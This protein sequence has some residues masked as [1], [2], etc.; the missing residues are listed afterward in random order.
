M[1]FVNPGFLYG[2]LAVSI[3][4]I[5]HLFNFRRFKKVYFTNVA[6][7]RELKQETQK[8]SRLK[9]LLVLLMRMLA[10]VALVL[11]FAR[12]FIPLKDNLI[13]PLETNSI[14]IYVDNSFSMQA[15][16]DKGTLLE[17]A[18]E[19]ALEI[20][21][22]Y[23]ASDRFQLLTN[24]MEGRH[25]RFV[26]KDEFLNLVDEI[27][28]SPVSLGISQVMTRQ[29][30]LQKQ[31]AAKVKTA[32]IIS[33]FQKNFVGEMKQPTDT[34][35]NSFLIPLQA[36]NNDNIFIDSCWFEAPVQQVNQ[37]VKLNVRIKNSSEN[38]YDKIPL[39]LSINGIQ[40]AVASFD[41]DANGE[42]QV[43][44]SYT[45][46]S[47]GIQTG[48]LE[49]NDHPIIFDDRFYF[50]YLVSSEISILCINE[51]DQNSYLNALFS[52]DS[53]F[54]FVNASVGMID[55]SSLQEYN[56]ILLN[57]LAEISSGLADELNR[58][59]ENG[60]SLVF[61]PAANPDFSSA[62]AMLNGMGAVKYTSLDS[63][64]QKITQLN[65]GH[66]IYSDVFDEIPENI[67]LPFVTKNFQIE[68]TSQM[69]QDKLLTMQNGGIFLNV[70]PFGRGKVYL[71]A[72][73]FKVSFSSF[74]KHAIFVPTLYKIAVSSNI[75]ENLYQVLGKKEMIKI[76][77]NNLGPDQVLTITNREGDFEIIPELR[78][79][80]NGLEIYTHNEVKKA[81]NYFLESQGESIKGLSFNYD[82]L[83]SEMTFYT[84]SE[85]E[86]YLAERKITGVQLLGVGNKPFVQTLSDLS[87][88]VQLWKYFVFAALGFLLA[89]VILL[90]F[91]K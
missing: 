71:F 84:N 41:L 33:D 16:S 75:E 66:P 38:T 89:E 86:N 4:V 68:V 12:P 85:L 23:K 90:R 28:I 73:P 63:T 26:S 72:V 65:I 69:V 18:K 36:F 1:D 5:I 54:R 91:W 56:L 20:A 35:S 55:Y 79:V 53:T 2:L 8:Q 17:S 14:S 47:S 25:Q 64:G 88:G 42:T 58:F 50:S 39:K 60:G 78:H 21:S 3:P 30:E 34:L 57:E 19:K 46:H 44:L 13:R 6:F 77:Q 27:G 48:E 29:E 10:I 43:V 9:H 51:K 11:A 82:R 70:F 67:D 74:P 15:E 24:D 76:R 40:K 45:N 81:G 31:E 52:T 22:V 37:Q 7:I 49:I 87:Q 32:Y 83:E 61:I 62:N 59:V 80:G